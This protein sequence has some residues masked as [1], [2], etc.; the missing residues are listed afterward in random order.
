MNAGTDIVAA[1]VEL[2]APTQADRAAALAR[3]RTEH[4]VADTDDS[5]LTEAARL[6]RVF[7]TECG[8]AFDP[9]AFGEMVEFIEELPF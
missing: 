4:E 1:L 2:P 7:V 8:P 5:A 6:T 9:V 3:W